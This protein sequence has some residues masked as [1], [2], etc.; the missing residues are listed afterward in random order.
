[1]FFVFTYWNITYAM[2]G[3]CLLTDKAEKR[4]GYTHCLSF[5]L[6]PSPLLLSL[7]FVSLGP[8]ARV[9]A[10]ELASRGQQAKEVGE[11]RPRLPLGQRLGP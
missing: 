3:A 4:L 6:A 1:M 7:S 8:V 5:S 10:P 9:S 11:G 2:Q